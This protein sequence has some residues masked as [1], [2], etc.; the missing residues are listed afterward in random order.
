MRFPRLAVVVSAALATGG[1]MLPAVAVGSP[2][3]PAD[4]YEVTLKISAKKA[5]AKEDKVKLTGKVTPRPDQSMPS[6]TK[7]V[8]QVRYENKKTWVREATASVKKNGSFSFTVKPQ[9][10]LDRTYRVLK[11]GDQK[12]TA[13]KSR[14][15]DLDVVKWQWLDSIVPSAAE[16]LLSGKL[17]INGED[18]VHTLYSNR[19]FPTGF[20]EYTLGR[21]C[22]ALETTFGLSDR[23]E[24]GG[25][26]SIQLAGDGSVLYAREFSLGE[27]EAKTFDVSDV[28]RIRFDF[29][30]V[31]DTP[32]TEPAAGAARVLCD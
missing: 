9:T 31:A 17:P 14:T 28:Y 11:S 4:P 1:L 16:N 23:T 29:V 15:R 3:A 25:K 18:Y 8:L 27:S 21:N 26:A 22:E 10:A 2:A 12:A 30:Q 32:V 20:T 24:T 13:G 19:Y 5:V 6:S 7:V